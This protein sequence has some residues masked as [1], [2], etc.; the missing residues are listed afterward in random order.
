MR[1]VELLRWQWEGYPRYHRSRANLLLH[2][3]VVPV[4]LAGNLGLLAALLARSPALAVASLAAMLA[5]VAAQ[6]R[7]HALEEHPP[8]PFTGPANA[9][10]R[11]VLEQWITF[12][13]YVLTGGWLQALR[14]AR[15]T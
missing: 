1:L 3:V 10:S 14:R 8:E 12:P 2:I 11:L 5:S 9:V 7:G 4:F 13:R 15:P 6:G